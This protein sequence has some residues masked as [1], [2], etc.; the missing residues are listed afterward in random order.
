MQVE[1]FEPFQEQIE[2]ELELELIVATWT[3]QGLFVVGSAH[4]DLD[5]AAT[6]AHRR[7]ELVPGAVE[8]RAL[9]AELPRVDFKSGTVHGDLHVGNLFVPDA[10]NEA[11]IID[12]GSVR[13][14]GPL[15][16]DPACLEV[17]LAFTPAFLLPA[18]PPAC[19]T[20]RALLLDA[21][22][23]PLTPAST[24]HLSGAIGASRTSMIRK[25]RD[26]ARKLDDNPIG[27]AIAVAAQLVRFASYNDTASVDDRS[28]AYELAA[29]LFSDTGVAMHQRRA[30]QLGAP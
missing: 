27:Y 21:Y 6:A 15:L 12:Y 8:L 28:M 4:R 13:P 25:V 24:R 19:L 30:R 5:E 9:I 11:V 14:G 7:G 29:R 1:S 18:T 2:R 17:S 26:I 20:F 23:Y 3:D 10:S 22:R 16:I